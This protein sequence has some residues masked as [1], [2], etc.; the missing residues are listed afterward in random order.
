M[1]RRPGLRRLGALKGA[2]PGAFEGGPANTT[3][4]TRVTRAPMRFRP[5][6]DR[7]RSFMVR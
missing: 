6:L 5:G 2:R 3:A 4:V 7:Q 1:V